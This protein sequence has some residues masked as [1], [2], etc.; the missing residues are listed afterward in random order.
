MEADFKP[1]FI[2]LGQRIRELRKEREIT[3][4]Q[5]AAYAEISRAKLSE[6]EN[7]L[8]NVEFITIIKIARGLEVGIHELFPKPKK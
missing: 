1:E 5:L 4:L 8:V 7:G 3:Q 2:A 6:M